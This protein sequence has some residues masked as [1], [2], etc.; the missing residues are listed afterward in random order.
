MSKVILVILDGLGYAKARSYLGNVEGWVAAG[1]AQ[2]AEMRSV[3]PSVSGPCYVSI[4]TGLQPQE[5]GVLT[6]YDHLTRVE[7][8][9]IFSAARKAGRTT[10]A[11]AHS[12]FSIFF[13]RA[14]F[15]PVRDIEVDDETLPIQRGRFYTMKSAHAGNL[16]IPDDRDLFAQVTI[17][18]ERHAS[19]YILVHTCSPDSV[20]HAYGQDSIHLDKQLYLLDAALAVYL[21]RWRKAG[22]EVII[23]A[24]HGQT[25]RGHHGGSTDEM[26]DVP[27]YYFGAS[28]VAPEHAALCQTQI[29]PSVL[30][31]LDVPIPTSMRSAPIFS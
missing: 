3:V 8:P 19:D 7:R 12:F 10:G 5:H 6:N 1:E 20:G 14:P 4:H 29:A 30:K 26:R 22:H 18:A 11:A 23:T 16:A 21:P 24:D 31:L 15:D 13:Q 17:M 2:V 28:R 27:F 9:D 25:P